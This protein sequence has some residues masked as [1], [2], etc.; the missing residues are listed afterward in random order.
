MDNEAVAAAQGEIARLEVRQVAA[1]AKRE[2]LYDTF[3]YNTIVQ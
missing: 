2:K 1:T 3:R